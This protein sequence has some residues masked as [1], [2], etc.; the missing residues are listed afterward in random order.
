MTTGLAYPSY[1]PY[2]YKPRFLIL[3]AELLPA[4]RSRL[5]D[6][7]ADIFYLLRRTTYQRPPLPR[8]DIGMKWRMLLELRRCAEGCSRTKFPCCI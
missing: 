4:L 2:P 8:I 5:L 1:N 7:D 3:N 6:I